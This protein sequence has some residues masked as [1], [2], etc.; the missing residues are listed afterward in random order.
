MTNQI[1]AKKEF[2]ATR[3]NQLKEKL[4]ASKSLCKQQGLCI[5]T[6]GSYGRLEAG[7]TSDIDLFFLKSN[8]DE[9]V[10]KID[11]TLTDADIIISCREMDFPE[12]SGD[13]E[14]LEIHDVYSMHKELGGRYDDYHNYF[15]ARILLL[16]ES[17]PLYN[18]ELYYSLVR[19]I[20]NKYYTDFDK[21]ESEFEP[22]FLLTT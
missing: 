13:G 2:S 8:K 19:D 3:I 6:T 10:S 16:L 15:T 20:I 4:S 14:Y 22:I 18:E 12:F 5:Y 1:I 7:E 11:K 17:K 21:H 9:S